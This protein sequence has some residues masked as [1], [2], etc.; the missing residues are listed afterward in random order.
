MK[1]NSV[2]QIYIFKKIGIKFI[3]LSKIRFLYQA[4]TFMVTLL[5]S[6]HLL[7]IP[8]KEYNDTS[9]VSPLQNF[10]L[11]D[12]NTIK[13][14]HSKVFQNCVGAGRVGEGLRADWQSQLKI[15]RK[16]LGFKYLRFHGLLHDELGVYT[17]NGK[18]KPQYNFQYIDLVYDF[19][20]SIGMRPFVEVGFMTNDLATIKTENAGI[21]GMTDDLDNPGKKRRV[22]V[23]QWKSNV[24]PPKDWIKWENLITALVDHWV[25]RY[26]TAEVAKWPFEIWNEP[27][28]TAFFS[29]NDPTKRMEE[30]FELYAHTVKAI[31][32][33]SPNS[34]VGGPAGAGPVY[35]KKM[36]EYCDTNHI[37][38]D[39]ISFHTYGLGPNS[40]NGFDEF[41]GK[42]GLYVNPD[43]HSV[44]NNANSQFPIIAKTSKP[45]LPVHITEWSASYS[46]ADP[47]HDDYF[48]ASYIL[49]QLK[50]TE[51]LSSMSY[52]TFTDIFEEVNIP[53]H[54]FDG[55]FGP[56]NLQ[57][58]KKPAYFSYQFLN[59]L[60]EHELKNNDEQ[61]WVCRDDKGGLQALFW[62]LTMK[63][64]PKVADQ[65][66]FRKIRPSS[67]KKIVHF[68]VKSLTSGHYQLEVYRVGF[69]KND[70]Y[71]AYLK[72][73]SPNDISRYQVLQLKNIASGKAESKS[74]IQVGESGVWSSVYNLR[75]NDIFYHCQPTKIKKLDLIS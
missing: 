51:Y 3:Y 63:E 14:T 74:E 48:S 66:Y 10:I 68:S 52:W 43:P 75:N 67:L 8:S 34:R 29:P 12:Y 19:L 65:T 6:N 61:S 72:M 37:P 21:D 33:V 44:V 40:G 13:G 30:Y 53:P 60:G 36:I 28:H 15:C 22:T 62:D 56:I 23:F 42:G 64:N 55:G 27:N 7:A 31:K 24:T 9:V 70:A 41:A 54:P 47:V 59:Q 1:A 45:N 39:F 38:I 49:E 25:M 35:T 17:D 69:E 57:G 5:F 73:G 50:H 20:R 32:S 18:G 71:T 4:A 2:K 11:V 26:G 58:I 16:E 46:S